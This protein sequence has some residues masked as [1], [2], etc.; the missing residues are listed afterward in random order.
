MKS[1]NEIPKEY[2]RSDL[3][4]LLTE[5]LTKNEFHIS[6]NT[7]DAMLKKVKTLVINNAFDY[8]LY[9]ID[10]FYKECPYFQGN[11]NLRCAIG[12]FINPFY[13][14]DYS[15]YKK[16]TNFPYKIPRNT[17]V[18]FLANIYA[19]C[20][21]NFMPSNKGSFKTI[22]DY[23][24]YIDTFIDNFPYQE[25]TYFDQSI[26]KT[27]EEISSLK[28]FLKNIFHKELGAD[29]YVAYE[30]FRTEIDLCLSQTN[31]E[32]FYFMPSCNLA[33]LHTTFHYIDNV[34]G[35]WE[36][37]L[38]GNVHDKSF[39]EKALSFLNII[40]NHFNIMKRE[41]QSDCNILF[42]HL[43][44]V[45][46]CDLIDLNSKNLNNIINRKSS[47]FESI[48]SIAD[49]FENNF[50]QLIDFYST[51]DNYF[52]FSHHQ[53]AFIHILKHCRDTLRLY[54]KR[55]TA[56]TQSINIQTELRCFLENINQQ[57][58]IEETQS[59]R[60]HINIPLSL[61]K[62]GTFMPF[63]ERYF[64]KEN[65]YASIENLPVPSLN[66]IYPSSFNTAS[67]IINLSV[68]ISLMEWNQLT[69]ED[70]KKFLYELCTFSKS[71]I[72]KYLSSSDDINTS[73]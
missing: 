33:T 55:K 43:V 10:T 69:P 32:Y 62:S 16:Q 39:Y 59:P 30:N 42:D 31:A 27:V 23:V 28:I 45:S 60:K 25:I 4:I 34:F 38:F 21:K 50:N 68:P 58:M 41:T 40:Y 54:L 64:S 15:K 5:K 57:P 65:I 13:A 12:A 9:Y 73:D 24:D 53:E 67:E 19:I 61:K 52:F 56:N 2:T 3:T 14:T 20:N 36:R 51:H 35:C 48:D 11:N 8:N 72:K 44:P 26:Y 70:Q 7:F 66:L 1:N 47:Q 17:C 18:L 29:V 6:K 63:L 37:V 49:Y 22:R 71:L 46:L